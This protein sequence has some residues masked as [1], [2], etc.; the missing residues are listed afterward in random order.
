MLCGFGT[1]PSSQKK[2]KI[3]EAAM[4]ATQLTKT[5]DPAAARSSVEPL[6]YGRTLSTG[7]SVMAHA[8]GVANILRAIRNDPELISAAYLFSVPTL[9]QKPDEWIEKSFGENVAGLVRELGKMNDLSKRAR[10]ENKESSA[11]V[12]PEAL[13]RM[14]LAMSQDL[15]VVLLKLASRLQ[16]LRWFVSSQAPGAVEFGEETLAVYAPLANRLGIWQIKWELED[17]SLRFTHPAEYH[18]IAAELDESREERLE[19]MA[20]A[21]KKIQAL[22]ISHGIQAEVSGRPKHI[23]SIWKKMQRKHLRFDQLFDVRAVRIIVETVE[24]CYEAL[25]IVQEHF[26]VLSKEYDDY[27]ANPKPNGYQSLHTVIT[28]QLGRPIEIQIRTRAMHEFAELGVA[29]HWRYKEAGNSNGASIAEEQRVAWLRQL[30][31]WRSDVGGGAAEQSAQAPNAEA[32]QKGQPAAPAVED[33]HV[34]CLTPQ[35]RIVELPAGATPVDF[36][37]QIHTQLGHRCR[38]AKVDGMMVPLNTKLKTG[39]T[40]E[41]IA[42]KVGQP[43]RDWLNPE[44]GYAASPRTRNK[45]RQWFNAEQLAQQIAEGRDRLDKELARLGK[46]AVKLDDLAKRLGFGTV[47][48]LCVAFAKEEITL[49]ALAQAVQP[50]K[51]APA[52]A[53]EHDL[54]LRGASSAASKGKVLVVGMDSLLTQLAR[55]CHPVPPDEIVGY[56]TRG[57]GVMIHRADCPNLKNMVDQDHDRLIEV[58]WGRAGDDALYPAD[59]LVIASDR[60]GIMKDVTEVMQ[61]EKVHVTALNTQILKGDQHMRFSLEV[62]GGNA[63]QVLLKGLRAVH[64]VLSAR[65][66]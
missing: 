27:I 61:R 2:K 19:F 66:L 25:S 11:A 46:T 48:E 23:Y 22:M 62:K 9:V 53:P 14:F 8:D 63:M 15:R 58:S 16:T 42:A 37:Y 7:E 57:R 30:L 47:D 21:V 54:V 28:D 29:A 51:P 17:L 33:D 13:R 31:A 24:Q 10:S 6:Y 49:T 35:G 40:V 32:G 26:T 18:Q 36:A 50:P 65:R 38:G 52:P 60:S 45:V 20:L 55:C 44:L 3:L 1:N 34:Y 56:V 43:S 5:A 64:G 59:V 4:D 39:Q 41:I 12:Q